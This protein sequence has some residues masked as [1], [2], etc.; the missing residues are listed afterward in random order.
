MLTRSPTA[1][2]NLMS[3]LPH[4]VLYYLREYVFPEIL[5]HQVCVH[6]C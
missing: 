4:I 6:V 5:K 2:Y 3:R 1:A